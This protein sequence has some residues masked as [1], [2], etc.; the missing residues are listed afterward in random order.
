MEEIQKKIKEIF[1]NF[2][3][4]KK[5][6]KTPERFKILH[7]I[8]EHDSHFTIEELFLYMK[9][10]NYRVSR[11]TLYNTVELLLESGLIKKHQFNSKTYFYEK[12]LRSSQHDH[13]ICESCG[14][15]VEFCDPRIHEIKADIGELYEF[16]INNHEIYFYGLCEDCVKKINQ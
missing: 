16:K 7:E 2:I 13:L 6:R 8:Y 15:I 10:K 4:E 1:T 12:A 3:K 14:K 11:A 9:S 5:L